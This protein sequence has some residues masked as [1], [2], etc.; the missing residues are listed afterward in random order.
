MSK[1]RGPGFLDRGFSDFRTHGHKARWIWTTG[2]KR[3]D[4]QIVS[5][6]LVPH[7]DQKAY[8]LRH[9]H[10]MALKQE[11]LLA[12]LQLQ[13][14]PHS[15]HHPLHNVSRWRVP[16]DQGELTFCSV[17]TRLFERLTSR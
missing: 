16:H 4:V 14:P 5:F 11:L 9:V 3:F 12:D 10:S 1:I 6:Y 13:V 17:Q 2:W 15:D 7:L 8:M